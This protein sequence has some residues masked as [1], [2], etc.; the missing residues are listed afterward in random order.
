[1][2]PERGA[3]AGLE[4]ATGG[5]QPESRSTVGEEAA[6]PSWNLPTPNPEAAKGFTLC[7]A[8]LERLDKRIL[9][10]IIMAFFFLFSSPWF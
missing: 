3:G 9:S 7:L 8:T 4:E 10:F 6:Q 5:G 1:M 2:R